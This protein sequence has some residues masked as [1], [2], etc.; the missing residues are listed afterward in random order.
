[1]RLVFITHGSTGDTVP[2]IRLAA[3]AVTRG[4]ETTFLAA[5]Y[6]K[7]TCESRGIRFVGIPPRGGVEEHADLMREF[8]GIRDNRKLLIA[9]FRHADRWFGEVIPV[10]ENELAGADVLVVSYLFALYHRVSDRKGIPSVSVHFCPNTALSDLRCPDGVPH[11]PAFLPRPI[12]RFWAETLNKAADRY[13]CR[14]LGKAVTHPDLRPKSFL[15]PPTNLSLVLAP[16]RPFGFDPDELRSGVHFTG[17]LRGGFSA[18]DGGA[19]PEPPPDFPEGAFVSFGSV[20]TEQMRREFLDLYDSWPEDK[21]LTVQTGWFD[22]PPPP[23]GKR[24]RI[25]GAAPHRSCFPKAS[26]VIHHGGAGTTTSAFFAGVPQIVVPHFADQ[27]FWAKTVK[28]SGCGVKVGRRNWG[29][30]LYAAVRR[31]EADPGF[32]KNAKRFTR[33]FTDPGSAARA[34]EVMEDSF[35]KGAKGRGAF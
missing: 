11:P 35:K 33:E 21:P 8:S 32:A 1:M 16:S 4:H 7:K 5:T 13:V 10:L 26:V 15:I 12:R 19:D 25:I 29:R 27:S 22:P 23:P 6:W 30:K 17:F 31:I 9:M 14:L 34:I 2:M 20:T 3:E 24:I 28:R 18:D